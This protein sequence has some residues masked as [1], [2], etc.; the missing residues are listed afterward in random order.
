MCGLYLK[1]NTHTVHLPCTAIR[2]KSY[3][4]GIHLTCKWVG[5]KSQGFETWKIHGIVFEWRRVL[6]ETKRIYAIRKQMRNDRRCRLDW[7]HDSESF[8]FITHTDTHTVR[9]RQKS[10]LCK[11]TWSQSLKLIMK[12]SKIK[13]SH[14]RIICINSNRTRKAGTKWLKR[15]DTKSGYFCW[16]TR[17]YAIISRSAAIVSFIEQN[18]TIIIV[19][20]PYSQKR[21]KGD[22]VTLMP[23]ICT[24]ASWRIHAYET[25]SNGFFLT[26]QSQ[27]RMFC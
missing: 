22:T 5:S 25:D 16:N 11:A 10:N 20:P 26:M 3:W 8:K 13:T 2:K 23:V 9:Q 15:T 6:D 12:L 7:I 18:E 19:K 4:N 24:S 27:F 1:Y 21:S 14:S 17:T